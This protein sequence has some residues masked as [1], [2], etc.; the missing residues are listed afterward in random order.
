MLSQ[1]QNAFRGRSGIAFVD[2]LG[3]CEVVGD[4]SQRADGALRIRIAAED[5]TQ[6]AW[7][8]KQQRLEFVHLDVGD[9]SATAGVR[10]QGVRN[11]QLHGSFQDPCLLS[12]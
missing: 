10:T 6:G 11:P 9:E 1:R 8:G 3:C 4:L 7:L 12:G 2:L 5:L